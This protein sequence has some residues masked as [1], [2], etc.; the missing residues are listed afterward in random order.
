[1]PIKTRRWDDP[2]EDDDGFRLLVTRYRPRGLPKAV[3]EK[4]Q[5]DIE[6][7]LAE[8]DIRERY[9]T[10]GYDVF[11]TTKEQYQTFIASESAK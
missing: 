10:F 7:A 2:K 4:I 6:A 1:M 5:R 3:Q 11:P 8:P 9:A